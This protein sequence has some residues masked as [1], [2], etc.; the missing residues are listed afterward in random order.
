MS[1][2]PE[3]RIPTFKNLLV[4]LQTNSN[5]WSKPRLSFASA[6]FRTKV[7]QC[8]EVAGK[9]QGP[10]GSLRKQCQHVP[11]TSKVASI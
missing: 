2:Q 4:L 6:V 10:P 7:F 11:A 1:H 5:L 8:I 3:S 9:P